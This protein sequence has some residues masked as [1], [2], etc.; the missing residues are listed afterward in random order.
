VND[1][2][3]ANPTPGQLE[4]ANAIIEYLNAAIDKIPTG[5][6]DGILGILESIITATDP[7][8]LDRAWDS[9]G[10]GQMIGY[11]LT[12][13]NPRKLKSD[14]ANTIPFYLVCDVMVKATGELKTATT[15]SYAIMSQILT[16]SDKNMLPMDFVPYEAEE[17]TENG[18]YPQHLKVWRPGMPD[19]PAPRA[20][21]S[22]RRAP[23]AS[24]RTA[25]QK[26]ADRIKAD[27]A[28]DKAKKGF[29]VPE[30]PEF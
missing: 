18:F 11:R 12:V 8:Q 10:F 20:P 22:E 7:T 28:A 21:R 14:F 16:A 29:D 27:V 19:E 26:F 4:R 13:S 9:C 6:E 1:L 23:A 30:T 15:G 3:P 17:P 25:E 24:P 5:G 2:L